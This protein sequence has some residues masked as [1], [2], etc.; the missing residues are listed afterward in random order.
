MKTRNIMAATMASII[1]LAGLSACGESATSSS[2][3]SNQITNEKK[4]EQPADLT[5]TWK[6]VNGEKDHYQEATITADSIEINWI[7]PD[8][9]SLYWSGSYTAPTKA[10][11]FSWTS[12]GDTEKMKASLLGSQDPT[13]DFKYSNGE[14]TYQSSA[15]G[16]TTTIR[17]KKQ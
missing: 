2:D 4:I 17:L 10:G 9:K 11:D 3:T 7:A 1:L 14:I 12:T 5:G 16:T 13:K 8:T 15:M 6:Q